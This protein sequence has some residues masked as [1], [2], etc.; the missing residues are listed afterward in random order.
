MKRHQS[1]QRDGEV[2][3]HRR[4]AGDEHY[5]GGRKIRAGRDHSAS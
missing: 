1:H 2:K 3:L 4:S 5:V